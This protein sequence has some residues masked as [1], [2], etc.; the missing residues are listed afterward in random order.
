MFVGGSI[1]NH[2][3]VDILESHKTPTH[4][5][6]GGLWKTKLNICSS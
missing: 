3:V 6:F 4:S 5:T 2:E 1:N